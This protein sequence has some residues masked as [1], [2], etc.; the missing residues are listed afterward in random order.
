MMGR[1]QGVPERDMK[2]MCEC[3]F[4]EGASAPFFIS[5]GLDLSSSA[6]VE[7]RCIILHRV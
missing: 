5:K 4:V 3:G 1:T 2:I 6:P 7:I